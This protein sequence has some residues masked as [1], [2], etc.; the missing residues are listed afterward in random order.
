[1]HLWKYI[2]LLA[3]TLASPTV[4]EYTFEQGMSDIQLM[5]SSIYKGRKSLEAYDGGI[6]SGMQ[7]V[8]HIV[9]GYNHATAT[10]ENIRPFRNFTQDDAAQATVHVQDM[11]EAMTEGLGEGRQKV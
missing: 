2:G 5:T 11:I 8:S 10:Q 6:F 3:M 7:L 1:M 9:T 4:A